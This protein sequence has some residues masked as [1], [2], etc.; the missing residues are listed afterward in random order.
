MFSSQIDHVSFGDVSLSPVNTSNCRSFHH[1]HLTVDLFLS[2]FVQDKSPL[3]ILDVRRVLPTC[4]PY[5]IT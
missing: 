4:P 2:L 1:S 3:H 5:I